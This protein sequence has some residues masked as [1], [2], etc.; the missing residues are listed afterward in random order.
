MSGNRGAQMGVGG[1]ATGWAQVA[2]MP[3]LR[4]LRGGAG[5]QLKPRERGSSGTPFQA[6][7]CPSGLRWSPRS[8]GGLSLQSLTARGVSS[9][10]WGCPRGSDHR[11]GDRQGA[12]MNIQMG[13]KTWGDQRLSA[14]G[15]LDSRVLPFL[16]CRFKGPLKSREL[17]ARPSRCPRPH[18]D[19]VGSSLDAARYRVSGVTRRCPLLRASAQKSG[20]WA[21]SP[22]TGEAP[23][24]RP[25]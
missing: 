15:G 23:G 7:M 10:A 8:H 12:L 25:T 16:H 13:Q 11:R 19:G 17:W 6:D 5:F 20:L 2:A 14:P 3:V 18:P 9:L 4:L 21:T 1:A 24:A 22:V